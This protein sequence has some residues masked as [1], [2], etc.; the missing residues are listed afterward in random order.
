MKKIKVK[1]ETP[2]MKAKR[3]VGEAKQLKKWERE[4][5]KPK[6][7]HYVAY[8]LVIL[9]MVQAIDEITSAINTQMQSEIAIGLFADRMSI[10]QLLSALTMPLL[11]CSIFYKALSDRYGR[12]IFLCINTLGMGTG[13]FIIFLAGKIGSISGIAMYILAFGMINFFITNDTQVLYIMETAAPKKRATTF[14]I[15]K[16]LGMFSVM[17]IPIMR[18]VFMGGDVTRWNY[19]YLGP[20]VV[21]I[22]IAVIC[23]F[24]ARESDVFLN[25]RITYLKMSDEERETKARDEGRKADEMKSQGGVGKAF[26]FAFSHK[27]L[28]WIFIAIVTFGLAA[29]G[30]SYY[31]KIADVYYS[32]EAVTAMLMTYPVASALVTLVNG[33]IGDKFGRKKTVVIMTALA[34][35]GFTLFFVG[36]NF[37]WN[38]YAVGLAIGCYI[39]AYYGACDINTIMVGE[40]TPTNLR[41]SMMSVCTILNMVSKMLAMLV[42]TFA[43]LATRDNYSILGWICVLGV[44]P[45]MGI[46]LII[47][48]FK[49]GDTTGMDLNQVTGMEWEK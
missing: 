49:V 48:A 2:E 7:L 28:R 9:A 6:G 13:L 33:F 23:F 19:V 41:A 47:L 15:I 29:F 22:A 37:S 42:P 18:T 34:F 45:L 32:T 10:M 24:F 27:Q 39:G 17:L 31:Q 25:D 20:G 30:T 44:V 4:A 1:A 40:S 16:S 43:L 21:A 5:K 36:C 12:K 35:I 26:Q 3:K 11:V 8:I 46:S 38:P 14:A